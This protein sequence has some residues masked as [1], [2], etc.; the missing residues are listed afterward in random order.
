M[1][2][3]LCNKSSVCTYFHRNVK[4]NI[5][6][7]RRYPVAACD[8]CHNGEVFVVENITDLYKHL[9]DNHKH[10]YV[11]ALANCNYEL[12]YDEIFHKMDLS[13]IK[14]VKEECYN[15][16]IITNHIK[17]M[18]VEYA[19][20][21]EKHTLKKKVKDIYQNRAESNVFTNKSLMNSLAQFVQRY[22]C[23]YLDFT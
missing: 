22:L 4:L 8:V 6:S 1:R 20:E 23:D 10:V 12:S 19:T 16:A 21:K 14:F 17:S 11:Q 15:I 2:D 13:K 18:K 7:G 3:Y 9:F 5:E